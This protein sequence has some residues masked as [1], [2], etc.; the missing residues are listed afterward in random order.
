MAII[1]ARIM[2]EADEIKLE[3]VEVKGNLLMQG[4]SELGRRSCGGTAISPDQAETTAEE[5]RVNF[6]DREA[7]IANTILRQSDLA[8][9]PRGGKSK[10]ADLIVLVL[11]IDV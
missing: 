11:S 8:N 3:A 6:S 10:G 4:L 7:L 1:W 9:N 2:D 5:D